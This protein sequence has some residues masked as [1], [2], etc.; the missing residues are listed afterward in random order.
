VVRWAPRVPLALGCKN[1]NDFENHFQ[2]K[3]SPMFRHLIG[4]L[5]KVASHYA[6]LIQEMGGDWL[7][8]NGK[9]GDK[10]LAA[11]IK[12]AD[13]VL[14]PVDCNSHGA[15]ASTKKLFR[16]LQRSCYFLRRSSISHLR[17]KLLE[18]V[19]TA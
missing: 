7:R 14:C 10:K 11:V 6:H 9:E 17:A 4:D 13:I 1:F 16:A 2:D 8:D 3:I 15:V 18:V 12:Q 5:D 19:S